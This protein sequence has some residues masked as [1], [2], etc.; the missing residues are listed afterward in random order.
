M[1][2]GFGAAAIVLAG[3]AAR[4]LGWLPD[5]FWQATPAELAASLGHS[6]TS[7]GGLGRDDLERLMESENG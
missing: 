7:A 1:S 2:S 4:A 3:I 6:A 5:E